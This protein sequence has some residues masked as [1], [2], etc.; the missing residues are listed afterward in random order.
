[1]LLGEL[2]AVIIS[3]RKEGMPAPE[4]F[5][6]G[7]ILLVSSFRTPAL[8][9]SSA[10]AADSLKVLKCQLEKWHLGVFYIEL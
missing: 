10:L 6:S 5:F 4:S 7:E 1:M 8:P 3:I 9:K 2:L